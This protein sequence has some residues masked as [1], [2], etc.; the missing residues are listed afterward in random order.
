MEE[1]LDQLVGLKT[2]LGPLVDEVKGGVGEVT[3]FVTGAPDTI[4]EAF[5]VP[6]PLCF[7]TSCATQ[8]C[9]PMSQ[10]LEMVDTLKGLDLQ[11]MLDKLN[12]LSENMGS[13]DVSKVK[14]PVEKFAEM[15]S[16]GV[17]NLDNVVKGAKMAGGAAGA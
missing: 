10:L 12:E 2:T 3:A 14:A 17:S 13:L 16:G 5:N 9:P 6:T 4:R 8:S 7:M 11:P 1:P 15:A